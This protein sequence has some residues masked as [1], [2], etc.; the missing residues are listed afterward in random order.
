[1]DAARPTDER[2]RVDLPSSKKIAFSGPRGPGWTGAAPPA[3]QQ[4][5]KMTVIRDAPPVWA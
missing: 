5:F 1:M 3:F 2:E 4:L